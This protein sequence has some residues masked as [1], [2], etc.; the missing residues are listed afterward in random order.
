MYGICA[1]HGWKRTSAGCVEQKLTIDGKLINVRKIEGTFI[2]GMQMKQNS[3]ECVTEIQRNKLREA[4]EGQ[5]G[6]PGGRL[7]RVSV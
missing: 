6:A 1:Q 5:G 7:R 2:E 4:H 3:R